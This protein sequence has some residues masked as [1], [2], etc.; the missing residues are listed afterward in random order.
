VTDP[1]LP[2]PTALSFVGAE[3][4]GV[5]FYGAT[6]GQEAAV[7]VQLA[8][9]LPTGAGGLGTA[10]GTS[11]S[12]VPGSGVVLSPILPPSSPVSGS[13][14]P[15]LVSLRESS[16]ALVGTLLVLTLEE[17]TATEQATSSSEATTAAAEVAA[18]GAPPTAGQGASAASGPPSGE[19]G[20]SEPGGEADG[21]GVP[22][23]RG[24]WEEF[25][26]G[27]EWGW[28]PRLLEALGRGAGPPAAPDGGGPAPSA[29]GPPGP[30]AADRREGGRGGAEAT[31]LPG[32]S[33]MGPATPA[34]RQ[35]SNLG[36]PADPAGVMPPARGDRDPSPAEADAQARR[37][38]ALAWAALGLV[39]GRHLWK[40]RR[41]RTRDHRAIPHRQT[42][43]TA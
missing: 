6:E 32:S 11:P 10:P 20:E 40:R 2:S 29:P 18:A 14:V 5:S 36:T 33:G 17:G 16:L 28:D 26:M 23:G 37:P 21:G 38:P 22:P 39:A 34:D 9:G 42:S 4:G 8:L 35:G 12:E 19:G 15:R 30:G 3:G 13:G 24:A 25:V 41:R 1:E 31:G 27:L 43:T 7:L